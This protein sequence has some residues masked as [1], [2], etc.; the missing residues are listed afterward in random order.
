MLVASVAT[1]EV[2]LELQGEKLLGILQRSGLETLSHF[3]NVKQRCPLKN[4][5][6]KWSMPRTQR[7][8]GTANK[9]IQYQNFTSVPELAEHLL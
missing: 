5:V 2:A 8:R 7:Q 4:L 1:T 3:S 6:C 9:L